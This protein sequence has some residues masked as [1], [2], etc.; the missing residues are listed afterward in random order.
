MVRT[1][2]D[3]AARVRARD[4]PLGAGG[5]CPAFAGRPPQRHIEQ[6]HRPDMENCEGVGTHK[7]RPHKR[8]DVELEAFNVGPQR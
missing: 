3:L 5:G 6:D 7:R 4:Q 1:W 8:S 2:E